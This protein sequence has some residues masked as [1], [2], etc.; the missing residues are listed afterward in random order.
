MATTPAYTLAEFSDFVILH[1]GGVNETVAK[2]VLSGPCTLLFIGMITGAAVGFLK[3]FD[4]LNPSLGTTEMEEEYSYP[5]SKTR[6]Y[7]VNPGGGG[8]P[9]ALGLSYAMTL[10]AGTSG[11]TAPGVVHEMILV[12]KRGVS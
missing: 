12:L 1:D 11:A 2:D 6:F 7:P 5:V 9:F 3:L 10:D 8:L 4:S